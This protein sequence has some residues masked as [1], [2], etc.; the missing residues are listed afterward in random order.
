M[1]YDELRALPASAYLDPIK[2]RAGFPLDSDP[3]NQE[4]EFQ[5]GL[6]ESTRCK[7]VFVTAGGVWGSEPLTGGHVQ[8][9]EGIG[10]HA[11]S[12]DFWRGVLAG[13]AEVG[14]YRRHSE[15]YTVIKPETLNERCPTCATPVRTIFDHIAI[16][17]EHD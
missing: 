16:D 11:G 7:R 17:C 4:K 9:Y 2:L 3:A 15:N 6:A 14:V 13:P 8:S 12:A 1:T 10:Y 5:R